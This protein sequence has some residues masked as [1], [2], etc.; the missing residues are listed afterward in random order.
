MSF[1]LEVLPSAALVAEAAARRFVATANDAIRARGEFVVA[2]S[3]GSTPRNLYARLATE[4]NASNVDWAR[5]QVLWGDER[6]VPPDDAASNY[7]M[8]RRALLD[9]VPIP[10]SNVHRI[11]GEDD[12]AAAAAAYEQVLRGVLRR[13][14]GPPRGTPGARFDLV[15]LGLGMD[16]HTASL[17]P[18]S[19]AARDDRCWV[20]AEYVRTVSAWRI[21]LTPVILNAA[22]SVLFLVS[23]GAKAA[24]L[25]KVLQGP[26]RPHE[27][28]AQRIVPADGRVVWL[29]DGPAAA[30]LREI[31]TR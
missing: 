25:R 14:T 19:A 7:R 3:G 8:A 26:R 1:D 22:A 2:L 11:H 21:T 9:H 28:P 15:L 24:V 10:T 17:F 30:A 6:C 12:P 16:G 29:V 13:P 27:L 4:P 18:G 31:S 23:G 20:R 5:V